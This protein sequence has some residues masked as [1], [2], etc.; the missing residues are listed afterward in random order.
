MTVRRAFHMA[1]LSD[2]TLRVMLVIL[3]VASAVLAV[4]DGIGL[5]KVNATWVV[6][7]VLIAL[8]AI[9]QTLDPV[10]EIHSDVRYLRSQAP[11]VKV[12]RFQGSRDFY[13][14][15]NGAVR[16]ATATLDLTHIRP[17]APARFGPEGD[18]STRLVMDFVENGGSVRRLIA[19]RTEEMK[20]WARELEKASRPHGNY[21][22]SVVEWTSAV[23]PINMAIVDAKA[24]FLTVAG[25]T[26]DRMN[27]IGIEDPVIGDYFT[28]YYEQLYGSAVEL[29]E[30]L[31]R[32]P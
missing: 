10:E 26:P 2:R 25:T 31:R 29:S 14:V 18:T 12:Q 4:L 24:V 7:L 32:N 22:V 23:P 21:H 20:A 9:I 28:A 8:L 3:A 1:Q 30:W 5:L 11:E 6:P 15:Y 19:V 27:A 17:H 13:T 16:S